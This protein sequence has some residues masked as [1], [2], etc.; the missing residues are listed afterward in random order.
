MFK[1]GKSV[2][3][4]VKQKQSYRHCVL[5]DISVLKMEGEVGETKQMKETFGGGET[6]SVTKVGSSCSTTLDPIKC[7]SDT[8]FT[9]GPQDQTTSG[10]NCSNN[11]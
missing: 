10:T 7:P 11:A 9:N 2:S 5:Y 3:D 6:Q 1:N 4:M 8:Y